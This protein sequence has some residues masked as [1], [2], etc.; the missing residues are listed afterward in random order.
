MRSAPA[1]AARSYLRFTVAHHLQARG[2]GL[3]SIGFLRIG[4][5]MAHAQT[6]IFC[7]QFPANSQV[8]L[9]EMRGCFFSQKGLVAH[10]IL[11]KKL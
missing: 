5:S 2:L 1:T 10:I 9:G 4:S 3:G 7:F 11:D 6:E 8:S